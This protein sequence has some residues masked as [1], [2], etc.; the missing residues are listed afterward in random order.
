M[1]K[2]KVIQQSCSLPVRNYDV[3]TA[4][5]D[6]RKHSVLLGTECKRG[7]IIG[8][9]GCGKTN[10]MLSLLEH[11]N[12]LRFQNVYLYSKTLNQPKYNYL[13]KVLLPMPEIGFYEYQDGSTIMPPNDAKSNSV[14]I[15]DDV[16]CDNQSIIRDYFSFGRHKNIDCFYLCQTYSSIPKQLVRD[17]ANLIIIFQQDNTNLKHIYD[18][19]VTT[20]MSFDMFKQLCSHCWKETYGFLV[21][22]KESGLN[23][24]R[25]R[26]GFDGFFDV[27]I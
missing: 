23:S 9:S 19:H 10:A 12:G 13:R 14:I 24:G 21:I 26:K 7:L 20:D 5:E 3:K 8:R 22:D 11:P 2:V 4:E 6:Y 1:N 18:D 16:V 27:T 15:F 25:Y 17:N